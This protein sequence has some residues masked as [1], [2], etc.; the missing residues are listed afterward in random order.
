MPD[1][2]LAGATAAARATPV[3]AT[4]PVPVAQSPYPSGAIHCST[5]P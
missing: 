2:T 5:C 1:L 3:S 4:N